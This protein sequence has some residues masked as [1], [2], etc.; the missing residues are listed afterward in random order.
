MF[1]K[2]NNNTISFLLSK[3][4]FSI[5][6]SQFLNKIILFGSSI[7][8]VR[9]LS[10]QEF[11]TWSYALNILNFFLLIQGLGVTS[12][13]LQYS[14]SAKSEDE[15]LSYFK[16]GLVFG[17]IVNIIISIFILVF[18]IYVKLPISGSAGILK[19]LFLIPLITLVFEIIQIYLRASLRNNL[20]SILSSLNSILLLV[21]SVLGALIFNVQGVVYGRYLT[22]LMCILVGYFLLK[23]SFKKIKKVKFPNLEQRKEFFKYSIVSSFNNSISSIVYL[24]DAFMVGLILKDDVI[25]ASYKVATLIPFNLVFIPLSIMIFAYPYF[26]KLSNEKLKIKTYYIKLV[27]YLLVLN[28]II[29]L[30]LIIFAPLIIKLI[31][32]DNYLHG[33]T[34]EIFRLLVFGYF[35]AGTFR[36]PAGN[37]LASLKKVNFNMITTIISGLL[38]VLLNFYF[39]SNFGAIG[40][41]IATV[42]VFIVSSVVSNIFLFMILKRD[43]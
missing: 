11:A 18:A 20:F 27:K 17:V 29:S 10:V 25:L 42:S 41:A 19:I 36:I 40:A 33:N 13:I 14:S 38:T 31:F 12:G 24:I 3:G 35:I 5:F 6:S 39:I 32:G 9:I 30:I 7:L 34:V 15:S 2:K 8:L 22:Y 37:I 16:L 43:I 21:C 4:F 23:D 28:F 26:A 1:L